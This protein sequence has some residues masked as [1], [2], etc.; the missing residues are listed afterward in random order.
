[1]EETVKTENQITLSKKDL[2]K[3][4]WYWVCW[5]QICYNYERMMGLGFCQSMIP[6]LK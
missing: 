3:S 1:M 2:N 6:V 5:G 4:W